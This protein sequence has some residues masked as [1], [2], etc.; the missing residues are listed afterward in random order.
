MAKTGRH[1]DDQEV[2]ADGAAEAT[3]AAASAT[4]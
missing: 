3:D 1:L 4:T 2:E